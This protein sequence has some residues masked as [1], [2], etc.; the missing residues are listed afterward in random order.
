MVEDAEEY[1]RVMDVLG[2][3]EKELRKRELEST[4]G[5]C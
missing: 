5:S 2:D 1:E 3:I 4:Y